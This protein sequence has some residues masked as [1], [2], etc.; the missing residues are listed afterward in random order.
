[1]NTR[2]SSL[3]ALLF[4]LGLVGVTTAFT[5]PSF[6]TKNC[7]YV[8]SPCCFEGSPC[9]EGVVDCCF[10]GSPCCFPGSPCCDAADCCVAK[11]ACCEVKK[12]CCDSDVKKTEPVIVQKKGCCSAH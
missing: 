1:M 8:G 10:P 2:F 9:C 11:K 5:T 6:A 7:C 4:V 3:V 12:S